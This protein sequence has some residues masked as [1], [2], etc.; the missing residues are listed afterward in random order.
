VKETQRPA[1]PEVEDR[2]QVPTVIR[3][4]PDQVEA[5]AKLH[6]EAILK[7]VEATEALRAL[8]P[9]DWRKAMSRANEMMF[10]PKG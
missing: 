10:G 5:A 1:P 2:T 9:S 4:G 8:S 7:R 6:V 3:P